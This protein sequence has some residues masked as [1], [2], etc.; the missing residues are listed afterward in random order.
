EPGLPLGVDLTVPR[1]DHH[2][3][4]PP[5]AAVL[6]YT[7]G[8]VEHH[9]LHLEDG[10]ARL[11]EIATAHAGGPLAKLCD[12]LLDADFDDDVTLLAVRSRSAPQP[13]GGR[14]GIGHLS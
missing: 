12:A 14:G 5:G 7:D 2:A 11:V 10:M 6:L 4:I 3:E 1:P 9:D 13:A 8:L